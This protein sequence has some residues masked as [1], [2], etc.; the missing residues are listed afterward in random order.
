MSHI[1]AP[2][3]RRLA[4][5]PGVVR[6]PTSN[7][8]LQREWPSRIGQNSRI[9]I[10]PDPESPGPPNRASTPPTEY[11]ASQS[12][13]RVDDS[14]QR[15]NHSNS[16]SAGTKKSYRYGRCPRCKDG[17][18][19]RIM[20]NKNG[21]GRHAGLISLQCSNKKAKKCLYY[22][23]PD[24]D[25]KVQ[26]DAEQARRERMSLIDMTGMPATQLL[27]SALLTGYSAA[28]N[29]LSSNLTGR[30][31]RSDEQV[32][33]MTSTDTGMKC[34]SCKDGTMLN[35]V[36]RTQLGEVT[37]LVCSRKQSGACDYSMKVPASNTSNE[38]HYGYDAFCEDDEEEEH[39]EEDNH[40]GEEEKVEEERHFEQDLRDLLDEQTH[41]TDERA[42]HEEDSN[43]PDLIKKEETENDMDTVGQFVRARS[44]KST[45]PKSSQPGQQLTRANL[46]S[47]VAA[48]NPPLPAVQIPSQQQSASQVPDRQSLRQVESGRRSEQFLSH[49]C[50]SQSFMEPPFEQDEEPFPT[51]GLPI[52]P[53]EP[54]MQSFGPTEPYGRHGQASFPQGGHH[55]EDGRSASQ[56]KPSP[57]SHYRD[58]PSRIR[59]SFD[60]CTPEHS[61]RLND[62]Y[63]HQPTEYSNNEFRQYP[64]RQCVQTPNGQHPETLTQSPGHSMHSSH[65]SISY[66][67]Y[68]QPLGFQQP[69]YPTVPRPPVL[70][71][72]AYAA[73]E[74]Y[75]EK[76]HGKKR[77]HADHANQIDL[78]NDSDE[79]TGPPPKRARHNSTQRT[80][81]WQGIPKKSEVIDLVSS[82][83]D[84]S[85]E[86]K[87][88]SEVMKRNKKKM[89]DAGI[90]QNQANTS[91]RRSESLLTRASQQTSP[92]SNQG[93]RANPQR[94]P[95]EAQSR[96]SG[97]L[98][99]LQASQQRAPSIQSARDS[100]PGYDELDDQLVQ[101][102]D[103]AAAEKGGRQPVYILREEVDV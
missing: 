6:V 94:Q 22:E 38:N 25:P 48:A 17:H 85:D 3:L 93:R 72:L 36:S 61:A 102:A 88:L 34:T 100:S 99:V 43:I 83:D 47:L 95:S 4:S 52:I 30:E 79:E 49:S 53:L 63:A 87:P 54:P 70:D 92:T 31:L 10:G 50:E 68:N 41:L 13:G 98:R 56:F 37:S 40:L 73:A 86:D 44:P 20:N 62:Q 12:R 18:R 21:T 11:L 39:Q 101:L 103:R 89:A 78:T 2:K 46:A 66:S 59:R 71:S 77:F 60:P 74:I 14:S 8:E 81:T 80:S 35:Q 84:D 75:D 82:D 15:S 91:R 64:N 1:K 67:R 23:L 26:Y 96:V 28:T 9:V 65:S 32:L 27:L 42:P 16:S 55:T 58:S 45:R 29:N 57:F 51:H 33:S 5:L 7:E 76:K 97:Q 69:S 24:I 90:Q 19:V